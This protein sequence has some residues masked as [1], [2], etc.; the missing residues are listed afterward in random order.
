MEHFQDAQRLRLMQLSSETKRKY[1]A[2]DD[3]IDSIVIGD[4]VKIYSEKQKYHVEIQ[5]IHCDEYIGIIKPNN[6][7][8]T[9]DEVV[10]FHRNHIFEVYNHFSTILKY[11]ECLPQPLWRTNP[12]CTS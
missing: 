6:G 5:S 3:E 7:F 2:N 12:L 8:K 9:K 1:V 4:L 11:K 10:V